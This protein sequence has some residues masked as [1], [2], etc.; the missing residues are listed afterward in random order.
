MKIGS[1]VKKQ[2]PASS[3]CDYAEQ[4]LAFH[5]KWLASLVGVITEVDASGNLKVHWNRTYGHFWDTVDHLELIS[6]GKSS[7][8]RNRE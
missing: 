3:G 4:H 5:D 6:E 7:N 1:L 2:R 8:T